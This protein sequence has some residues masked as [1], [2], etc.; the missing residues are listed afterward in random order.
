MIRNRFQS[1]YHFLMAEGEGF[2]PPDAFTSPVFKTGA[3]DHSANLPNCSAEFGGTIYLCFP[4]KNSASVPGPECVPM[5]LP[6]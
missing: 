1:S 4:I 2:E 6:T 5:T 3:I